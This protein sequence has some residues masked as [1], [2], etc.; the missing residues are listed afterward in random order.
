MKG[1]QV[2]DPQGADVHSSFLSREAVKLL[3]GKKAGI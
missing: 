2:E 1:Y 3:R